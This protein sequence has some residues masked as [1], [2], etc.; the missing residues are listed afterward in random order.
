MA[1]HQVL[2][3]RQLAVQPFIRISILV[4]TGILVQST[5]NLDVWLLFSGSLGLSLVLIYLIWRKRSSR[6]TGIIIGLWLSTA[7]CGV[8]KQY[9]PVK[10]N[11]DLWYGRHPVI[12]SVGNDIRKSDTGSRFQGILK[13]V[14]VNRQWQFIEAPVW[15]RLHKMV[16]LPGDLILNRGRLKDLPQITLPLEFDLKN[17]LTSNHLEGIWEVKE[18]EAINLGVEEQWSFTIFGRLRNHLLQNLRDNGLPERAFGLVSA[19]ILGERSEI[20]SDVQEAFRVS[21]L[22]HILAV[23]GMHVALIFGL[24]TLLV[25]SLGN[26]WL[27]A[28]LLILGVWLYAALSGLSPSVTRAAT[29]YSLIAIGQGLNR[30]NTSSLNSL[31]A[32]AVLMLLFDSGFLFDMGFQLSFLAV[33]GIVTL[34]NRYAFTSYSRWKRY[35]LQ[36]MWISIVAQLTTLPVILYH[37]GTFPVY[38][39]P[40]NL[41]AVPFSAILTY[42][43]ILCLMLSPVPVVAPFACDVLSVCIDGFVALVSFFSELPYAQISNIVPTFPQ[44]LLLMAFVLMLSVFTISLTRFMKFSV[45]ALL[46]MPVAGHLGKDRRRPSNHLIAVKGPELLVLTTGGRAVYSCVEPSL[47]DGF[48]KRKKEQLTP[49]SIEIPGPTKGE[50]ILRFNIQID[51]SIATILCVDPQ[52]K[53]NPWKLLQSDNVHLVALLKPSRNLRIWETA[54]RRFSIP[55]HKVW[56]KQNHILNLSKNH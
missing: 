53:A 36:A 39:L 27:K 2:F 5:L 38:F 14:Y 11:P 30:S 28:V 49:H 9:I 4:F 54:C 22:V 21:G 6:F 50:Q 19:L 10:Q 52:S 43:S 41:L 56:S 29:L 55:V 25:K 37:F 40:A 31:L 24:F 44:M 23:S 32:A 47:S 13:A 42:A 45:I 46:F 3:K 16:P 7:S 18:G 17:W 8:V 35:F 26:V 20:E 33:L 48:L 1:N 12:L 15:V 34:G 51:D